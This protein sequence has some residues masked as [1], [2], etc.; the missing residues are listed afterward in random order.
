MKAA[1]RET[2]SLESERRVLGAK[3]I[4]LTIV[5][6][7]SRWAL[8][9]NGP[10]SKFC[11]FLCHCVN[12]ANRFSLLKKKRE[13]IMSQENEEQQNEKGESEISL[14]SL[15]CV[16]NMIIYCLCVCQMC[17]FLSRVPHCAFIAHRHHH[18]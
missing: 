3:R 4:W 7:N 8:S 18:L 6:R 11:C 9:P 14:F 17:T 15:K 5:Q 12:R 10:H 2:I 1:Q 13:I 16:K